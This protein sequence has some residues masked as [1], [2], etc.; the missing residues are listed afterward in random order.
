MQNNRI[1]LP[2]GLYHTSYNPFHASRLEMLDLKIRVKNIAKY[3]MK[4]DSMRED[5]VG[6]EFKVFAIRTSMVWLNFK[7][8][9]LLNLAHF[10]TEYLLNGE[11]VK[12][13]ELVNA[14]LYADVT[15]EWQAFAWGLMIN[16][17]EG[18]YLSVVRN[19]ALSDETNLTLMTKE[20]DK[21]TKYRASFPYDTFN[22]LVDSFKQFYESQK[23][24]ISLRDQEILDKVILAWS[25]TVKAENTK[26][27][28]FY[29]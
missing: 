20:S 7:G 1:V 24:Q 4:S 14:F 12:Y 8:T 27:N 22:S 18:D 15:K 3:A 5:Y 16:F 9:E 2:V 25:Q 11:P 17:G 26:L 28:V 19:W 10:D 21:F 23:E 29:N 13:T 6:K